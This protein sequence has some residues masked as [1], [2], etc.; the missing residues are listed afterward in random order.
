MTGTTLKGLNNSVQS[1]FG[2]VIKPDNLSPRVVP[3]AIHLQAFQACVKT[4]YVYP[5]Y[6][7]Y[8]SSD[9]CPIELQSVQ[10]CDATEA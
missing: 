1:P 4:C 3:A 6:L 7:T 9:K 5:T 2:V 8:P 10:E